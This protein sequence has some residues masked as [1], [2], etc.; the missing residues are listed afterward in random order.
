MKEA[1]QA[2]PDHARSPGGNGSPGVRWWPAWIILALAAGALAWVGLTNRLNHQ[3]QY[4]RSAAVLLGT[5]LL[6][7]LWSLF[8][9]RLHGRVRLILVGAVFGSLALVVCLF[10][11]RGVT[12][13]LLPILEW[14]WAGAARPVAVAGAASG[15]ARPQ[16]A[17][18][19]PPTGHDFPQF[20]GPRR[21]ATM[22]GTRLERD[23]K[24]HPPQFLWRHE[25]G[26][27]WSGFA[28]AGPY[29]ITQE[30][31]GEKEV[32]AAYDLTTGRSLWTHADAAH[33]NTTI[34]GEGPRATPTIVSNRVFTLGATGWLNCLDLRTGATLWTTNV[35]Q[36]NQTKLPEWGMSSS[37]LVWGE[38]V[39]V[40]PGGGSQSL[41]AYQAATGW[42]AWTS[43]RDGP[44]YGSPCPATL[45]GVE[46]VL[47]F[48]SGSVAAFD[49]WTGK[50]LWDYPWPR[51]HPHVAM[52]VV[53]GPD[54]VLVSS[55]YGTGSEL[56]QVRR[57]DAGGWSAARLWKS[58]RLKAK[59]TNLVQRD[60]HI[61]GLD[62]GILAC[63]D[64]ATGEQ[65]WKEGRY[66]HGQVLLVGDLL[67]VS[68]ESGDLVLVEPVPLE[69]RE[70]G[71]VTIF[72]R[73]TWN[74]PALAGPYLLVRNDLEAAC[75]RLALVEGR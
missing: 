15:S 42:R 57:D 64:A 32:V 69:H 23:W 55:G 34:A 16:A 20:L 50:L 37:P 68:A 72:T 8:F 46:Q 63:L 58:V 4:L 10:R 52:P 13:D 3:E 28:V 33:Y 71:R 36:D 2:E 11:L 51:G 54:R 40:S 60:G 70:L 21:D 29:A 24:T 45:V 41:V 35:I 14:R 73:K 62:D 44:G 39:I 49:R 67:L 75:Y 47:A 31:R 17:V 53:L 48:N 27:G 66:G 65:R 30:Q 56:L 59:F 26:A 9:A 12:G 38:W 1:D 43:G 22:P 6:L 61:Y 18:V 74:P 7:L 19:P 25:V 5:G